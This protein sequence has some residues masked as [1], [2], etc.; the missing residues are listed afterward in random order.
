M[1]R[2]HFGIPVSA[3]GLSPKIKKLNGKRKP[4]F[5]GNFSLLRFLRKRAEN[6]IITFLIFKKQQTN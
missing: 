3:V 6:D 1:V 5:K 4:P 2:E